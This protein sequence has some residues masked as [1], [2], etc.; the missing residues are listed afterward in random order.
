MTRQPTPEE[1]AAALLPCE[2][3]TRYCDPEKEE[4]C[5][6]CQARPAVTVALAE[7]YRAQHHE[8]CDSLD[9][10]IEPHLPVK[11]CNCYVSL[12][13]ERDQLRQQIVSFDD[14]EGFPRHYQ[15]LPT[16]ELQDIL[17]ASDAN[18]M[19]SKIKELQKSVVNLEGQVE[20]LQASN[21]ADLA[22]AKVEGLRMARMI[23]AVYEDEDSD[24]WEHT[25]G[26]V[27]LTDA[28]DAEIAALEKGK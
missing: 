8:D 28:I 21:D 24:A 18:G 13:A 19:V 15:G 3:V 22:A 9:V 26:E 25:Y 27:L 23:F 7:A 1:Q 10:P 14:I 20:L 17:T 11:P 4:L 2:K 6:A 12:R 16:H 5:I